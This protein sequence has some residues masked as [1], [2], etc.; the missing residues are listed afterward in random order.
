MSGKNK[1]N[2]DF[3]LVQL[4]VYNITYSLFHQVSIA[5]EQLLTG[6]MTSTLSIRSN[7]KYQTFSEAC[8]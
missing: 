8:P 2:D 7:K 4:I 3:E 1:I 6:N 5:Y